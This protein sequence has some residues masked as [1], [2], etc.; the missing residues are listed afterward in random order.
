[1]WFVYVLK[2]VSND[3][4]YIGSTN[5]LNRR[6]LEHNEGQV[7]S[8]KHYAPYEI[9]AYVAV[10]TEKRARELEKYFKTGSGKAILKKRILASQTKP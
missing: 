9:E 4:I 2:S 7:P 6:L 5:N 3:F 8:T 10:K 1:M